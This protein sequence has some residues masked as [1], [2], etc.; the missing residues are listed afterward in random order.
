MKFDLKGSFTFSNDI[1]HIKDEMEKFILDF[2]KNLLKKNVEKRVS[3]EKFKI[4][5]KSM[6]F[7]IVSC[8]L[9]KV[10][11]ICIPGKA[12]RHGRM[13]KHLSMEI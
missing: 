12:Y 8:G 6:F 13:E 9:F 5:K 2:N 10:F 11:P 7:N 3:I 4:G 1:L